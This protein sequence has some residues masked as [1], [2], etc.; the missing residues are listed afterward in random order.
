MIKYNNELPLQIEKELE[1]KFM[2]RITKIPYEEI[3]I[4]SL[5]GITS[6]TK[7]QVF[8]EVMGFNDKEISL[9]DETDT[10]TF[11]T[12]GL[13]CP[14]IDLG[15]TVLIFGQKEDSELKLD[16]IMKLNVEW[17]LFNRLRVQER[18]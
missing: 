18:R 8:G 5:K 14:E 13:D 2:K 7:F 10:F 11:P 16:K 9:S 3:S 6:N 17:S 12:E 15:N 4:L 1:G